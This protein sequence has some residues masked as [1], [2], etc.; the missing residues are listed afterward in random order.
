MSS[1][2]TILHLISTLGPGGAEVM[3]CNL[4][5]GSQAGVRH[6]VVTT[7]TDNTPSVTER[8]TRSA[9]SCHHLATDSILS[10]SVIRRICEIVNQEKPQIIQTWLHKADL[11]GAIV[12]KHTGVP[13]VWGLHSLRPF[14]ISQM[15]ALALN[16]ALAAA[17]RLGPAKIISCSQRGITAHARRGYPR[18]KMVWIG[19]GID[20]ARFQP[21]AAARE[22]LRSE[23]GIP[24]DAT[25]VGFVGRDAP[26][27]DFPTFLH[28]AALHLMEFP[29]T[30]FVC[31]GT[32]PAAASSFPATDRI[33]FIPFR[34]DMHLV[35]P[36][37]DFLTLTSRS[38]AF[39]M[40]LIE[41][42]AC[43]VGCTATD[44]GDAALII[45]DPRF[46]SPVGNAENIASTWKA[47]RLAPADASTQRDSITQRF[48]L[49]IT[50]GKYLDLYQNIL[51]T[52]SLV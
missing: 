50:V 29:N 30:H 42:M 17:S 2:I 8:I 3:L 18:Q 36:A 19:N 37:F 23:L 9:A 39:P 13:V 41:A 44:V 20:A 31:C 22:T 1:P 14:A 33:H 32:S 51:S 47:R 16:S 28:A 45:G 34:Q 7:S 52:P 11:A 5:E 43:G 48:S 26:V 10:R 25:V 27:K 12:G 46:I 4:V 35:Y 21:N 40:V 49:Q 24:M 38:E 6:V 15:K